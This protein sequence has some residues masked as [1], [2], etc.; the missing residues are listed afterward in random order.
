MAGTAS[1]IGAHILTTARRWVPSRT[2]NATI[3]SIA[4]SWSVL[5]GAAPQERRHQAM[6]S[7]DRHLVKR[8]AGLIQ[9]LDPPFDKSARWILATS[10]AMC[11]ACAKTVAST[12]MPPMWA[13][14]AFAEMGDAR[15]AW[16][17]LRMIS[18]I[19]HGSGDAR[20]DI[21]KVEPYVM[22]AD[23]YCG[24]AAS[25]AWRLDLVHRFSGLDVSA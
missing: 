8:E 2:K 9:L 15:R 24:R 3:D 12:R 23:V 21:Y 25:G 4:Q 7:L 22:A 13:T 10:K 19:H 18:P 17:L 20:I 16:E 1:G 6:E 14:M 5:S 11:P